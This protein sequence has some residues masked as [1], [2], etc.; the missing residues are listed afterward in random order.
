MWAEVGAVQV[1]VEVDKADDEVRRVRKGLWLYTYLE[2]P[3][4]HQARR[5]CAGSVEHA[6]LPCSKEEVN[7]DVSSSGREQLGLKTM[8]RGPS[9][10]VCLVQHATDVEVGRRRFEVCWWG[11]NRNAALRGALTL[12]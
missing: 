5:S 9:R 4:Q 12:R 11:G 1:E 2:A 3:R 7:N 6:Y 8:R 10:R